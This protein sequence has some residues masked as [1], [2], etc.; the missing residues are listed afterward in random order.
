MSTDA[1]YLGN[2]ETT[3]TMSA[4]EEKIDYEEDEDEDEEEEEP[5]APDWRKSKEKEQLRKD[6]LEGNIDGWIA[7]WVYEMRGGIYKKFKFNNFKNNL[8]RL[9]FSIWKQ[10]R[11]AFYDT[12][13]YHNDLIADRPPAPPTR[14]QAHWNTSR[15]KDLL[16]E[17]IDEGLHAELKPK[18]LWLTRPEYQEFTSD[19]FRDHIYQALNAR[20]KKDYWEKYGYR[21]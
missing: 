11:R 10:Q 19:V 6:I 9:R 4:E 18:E 7:E 1:H 15:A 17:D 16:E 13:L 8:K 21:K 14:Q 5:K 12:A 3:K 2:G 20:A